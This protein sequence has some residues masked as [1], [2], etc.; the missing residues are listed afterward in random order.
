M[1]SVVEATPDSQMES[2]I[3]ARKMRIK[4]LD[5]VVIVNVFNDISVLAYWSGLVE[6][7]MTI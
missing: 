2:R 7:L 5:L 4:I 3:V 6:L 1:S